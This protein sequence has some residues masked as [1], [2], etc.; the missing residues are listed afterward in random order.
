M[1]FY[2]YVHDFIPCQT[3][4]RH[5]QISYLCCNSSSVLLPSKI[6]Y[7]LLTVISILMQLSRVLSPAFSTLLGC[8]QVIANFTSFFHLTHKVMITFVDLN[9]HF[10]MWL[11]L[12]NIVIDV[13]FWYPRYHK[14]SI[15]TLKG[16]F[17]F[18]GLQSVWKRVLRCWHIISNTGLYNLLIL[19]LKD[20][21][22]FIIYFVFKY[23]FFVN[24]SRSLNL[25]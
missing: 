4:F 20:V 15:N 12:I 18:L 22:I 13:C 3:I 10:Y 25:L 24:K 5:L 11:H 17:M 9:K 21:F 6:C 8:L 7:K 14:V 19:F 16:L 2:F 23:S 1:K